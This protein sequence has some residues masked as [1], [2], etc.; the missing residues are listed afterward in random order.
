MKEILTTLTQ[1][2]Q[3]TVPAEVR[4]LLGIKPRGKVA[5]LIEG[6]QVR[7]APVKFTLESAYGSVKPRKTP[8][9]FEQVIHQAM[10]EH[11]EE[12]VREMRD[13]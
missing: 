10:E 13:G 1:R 8:E 11:A 12:V 2:N 4:K 3:V 6:D 5:F 9:D 7:L